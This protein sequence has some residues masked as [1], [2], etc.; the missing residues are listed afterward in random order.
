MIDVVEPDTTK[1]I[2]SPF[3]IHVRFRPESGARI[4]PASFRVKYGWLNLDI[5]QRL[6]VS[7][8]VV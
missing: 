8:G 6:I 7:R 1:P 5:T 2:K 3:S 4:V